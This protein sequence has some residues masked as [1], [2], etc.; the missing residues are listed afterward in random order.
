[1][2]R[3]VLLFLLLC[4]CANKFFAQA[5]GDYQSAGTGLWS[6]AGTWQTW[7][8]ASW[9]AAG[10]AP[11]SANGVIT[12]LATHTV[13]IN[14]NVSVDQVVINA[15]GFLALTAGTLTIANGAGTDFTINGTF[16]ES[17]AATPAWTAGATWT[18]GANGTLIKTTNTSSNNWQLNYQGGIAT[19]PATS[20]WIIRRNTAVSIPLSSTSPATGSVYPNLT[21]ENNVAGTWTMSTVTSAFTGN[22]AYVTV[23]GNLDVGG[24]GTSTLDFTINNTNATETQVQ[25][26]LTVRTGSFLRNLGT[27]I[28]LQGNLTVSGSITY[29]GGNARRL[30]FSGGNAQTVSGAGAL[31][32]Y[33]CQLNKSSNSV[34]LSRSMTI[35]NVMT[36]T[37]GL[38]NTSAANLL[39][40][41]STGSVTGANNSSFVNGPVRYVGLSAFT[42]PVGKNADYQALSYSGSLGGPFWT[43]TFNNGCTNACTANGVNTGNG[44]WAIDNSNNPA[45]D[46]CGQ[47]PEYNVWYVSCKENGNASGAC[48]TGCAANATLHIGSTTSGDLGASYDAGGY[49]DILGP[50]WGGGTNTNTMVV[51]PTISTLGKTNITL[52][53]NYLHFGQAGIDYGWVDYSVNN[54]ASWISLV[55][56]MP[57]TSCCGGPCDN[58]HQGLWAT[59]SVVLPVAAENIP[60]FRLRYGWRND[61]DA[62]GND[63]SFAINDI[64]LSTPAP[65]CDFTCEYFYANPQVV[66]NNNLAPTLGSISACEYWI[67][68]R[69]A[70]TESKTLTLTWDANSC[71]AIT[72]ITDTR[73]AHFDLGNTNIW[74]DE[75]N[76][77]NTGTTAA[78][79][80]TSAAPVSYFS[81]FTIGLI[82]IALPIE[83]LKFDGMC[84][85]NSVLLNWSTASET[86]NDFFTVER[87]VDENNFVAIGTVDGA[88]NSS[89]VLHYSFIDKD[90]LPG[91]KYY[92]IRQ[93]DFNGAFTFS[94]IIAVNST[95]CETNTSL[96]ANASINNDILE[97]NYA[98]GAGPVSIEVF[99]A[100]GKF[101]FHESGLPEEFR[102]SINTSSWS[103]SVYFVR[104]TDGIDVVNKSVVK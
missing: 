43:E 16:T 38:I 50:G 91:E 6:A 47:I 49:C 87:S 90:D 40:I 5:V 8:G 56:P 76:G 98:H 81:P 4:C 77:G 86:N 75:G 10:A 30:I 51:S 68:T 74:Q 93:T 84:N 46:N 22:T 70:G 2:K 99:S 27:G 1:M 101:M 100:D 19:I 32:V 95:G 34:T 88:G 83:I 53:F 12:I 73:V 96:L 97:L 25:G 37:S 52:S 58:F 78:G 61:D 92:R 80:V 54:G 104:I 14:A 26:N 48:G 15:S 89:S 9:V 41:A 33:D 23:K 45:T 17:S 62:A 60:G 24:A 13:T 3:H 79:T 11:T 71:P 29:S 103:R 102:Y 21:L 42:F 59:Y 85:G 57:Q 69:N 18:M 35:D 20:N 28:N 55:N 31:S 7:N 72:T 94:S 66:Y 36:F 67:L 64:I 44:A 39:T 63:N 82:P 65:V